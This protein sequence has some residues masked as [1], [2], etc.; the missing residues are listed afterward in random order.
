VP[1]LDVNIPRQT[2]EPRKLPCGAAQKPEHSTNHDEDDPESDE[3]LSKFRHHGALSRQP[4]TLS[5]QVQNSKPDIR[6]NE[7]RFSADR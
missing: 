7:T 6:F 1:P 3:E 5:S 4:S 2:A